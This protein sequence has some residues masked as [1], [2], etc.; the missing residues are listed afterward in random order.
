MALSEIVLGNIIAYLRRAQSGKESEVILYPFEEQGVWKI[1][2][3]VWQ[4]GMPRLEVT[5]PFVSGR[6]IDAVAIAVQDNQFYSPLK[7]SAN[8]SSGSPNAA[9]SD[10]AG[11]IKKAEI[12]VLDSI[13]NLEELKERNKQTMKIEF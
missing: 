3:G 5:T 4:Y 12:T 6:F 7:E 1:V 2:G 13:V 11:Y 10:L 8:L 9:G